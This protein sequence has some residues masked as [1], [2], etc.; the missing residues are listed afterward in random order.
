MTPEVITIFE[1][2][3]KRLDLTKTQVDDLLHIKDLMPAG[4]MSISADGA[5][6]VMHYVGFFSY[7]KTRLQVLPKIFEKE[8]ETEKI[9][10]VE[11]LTKLLSESEYYKIKIL[12]NQESDSDYSDL[13]EIFITKFANEIIATYSKEI[14]KEYNNI[15]EDSGF[16]KGKIDFN[17][18]FTKC[19]SR[20]DRHIVL[21]DAYQENNFINNFIMTVAILLM[22]KTNKQHNRFLLRKALTYLCDCEF[23]VTTKEQI[24]RVKFNRLNATFENVF[25]IAKMFYYNETPTGYIGEKS[26]F[27]FMVKL[28]E[29]YEY[30]L[31]KA[32]KKAD[33]NVAVGYQNSH[34]L[35]KGENRYSI[36]PDIILKKDGVV[37]YIID[38]KYKYPHGEKGDFDK[39]G[40]GDIYQVFTYA[41]VYGVNKVALVYPLFEGSETQIKRIML[42]DMD[43]PI[44]L[45][46]I[47]IDIKKDSID[48]MGQKLR[49][50]LKFNVVNDMNTIAI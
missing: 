34:Q 21:Y 19:V 10:G 17:Q 48:E 29:L 9:Q 24:D 39:I 41:R 16:V 43:T 35:I 20:K 25:N 46:L 2:R 26:S 47:C 30:Y 15:T 18:T 31:Y 42:N 13:F 49:E 6:Q 32:L 27:S 22:N 50:V 4:S 36:K 14:H 8:T 7:G 12:N 23:M 40:Q 28:N 38:A 37:N 45:T 44:E 33:M 11:L 5:V 3:R 1:D